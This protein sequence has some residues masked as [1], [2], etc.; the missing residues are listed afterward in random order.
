MANKHSPTGAQIVAVA[1]SWLGVP[2]LYGG[3]TRA[4]VDC[5]GLVLN[6]AR[7]VGIDSC[8][9][10]SEEQWGWCEHISESESGPGDLVFFV[11]SEIDPPP[12]H[13]GIL[14]SPQEMINAP[15]T[16]TVVRYDHFAN[17]PGSAR[18]IGYGRMRGAS[19]SRSAN[20]YTERTGKAG[21]AS[22]QSA[23][24]ILGAVGGVIVWIMLAVIA[25]IIFVI[26]FLAVWRF[27][28]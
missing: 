20:P 27:N 17:G 14:V 3:T 15:F 11:G 28:A 26:L 6:V 9:R 25:V 1:R 23:D 16:G 13:V 18:I 21:A 2:Y 10:T 22:Q 12:G 5:S 7:A 4:G 8:P 24:A 19:R